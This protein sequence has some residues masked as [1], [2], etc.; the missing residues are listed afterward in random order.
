[1]EEILGLGES[2]KVLD[3]NEAK[4]RL[5]GHWKKLVNPRDPQS[6]VT[7]GALLK[8]IEEAGDNPEKIF[9][10]ERIL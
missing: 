2:F 3:A 5:L 4:N 9:P 10:K 1:M 8:L 6:V 7:V